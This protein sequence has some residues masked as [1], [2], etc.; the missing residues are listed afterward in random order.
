MCG[1]M[2]NLPIAVLYIISSETMLRIQITK[3]SDGSG[4]LCCVRANGSLT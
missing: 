2:M 4:V 1:A 3:Q